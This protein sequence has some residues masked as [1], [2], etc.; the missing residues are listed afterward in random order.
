MLRVPRRLG[1]LDA[2]SAGKLH[3]LCARLGC[4]AHELMLSWLLQI[5]DCIV[6]IPGATRT[7]SVAS[8]ARAAHDEFLLLDEDIVQFFQ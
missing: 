7:Q 3:P 5:D 8:I 6:P 4:S 1:V 2:S